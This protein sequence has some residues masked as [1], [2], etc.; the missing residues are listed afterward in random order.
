MTDAARDRLVAVMLDE[1]SIGIGTA[2]QEHE[3][4]VAIFDLVEENSFALA[5]HDRGPY[6]LRIGLHG[7]QLALEIRTA[8]DETVITHLLALK[9]FR[10]LLRDYLMMCDSYVD[11]IR[12]ATPDRI[13][14]I[15]MGRRG[16][17]NEGAEQLAAR[18]NGKIAA[19][20]D[21]LRRLFTLLTALH[22]RG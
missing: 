17:H 15:D 22:W 1:A 18:L 11:A 14:A 4:R 19:D 13:E 20:F 16:L 6:Q 8:G 10:G 7:A 5:G 2:D 21:T 9:P 12:T 3:R